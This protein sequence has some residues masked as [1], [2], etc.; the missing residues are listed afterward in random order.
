VSSDEHG[1]SVDR[2]ASAPATTLDACTM[3]I[4]TITATMMA[5]I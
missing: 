3:S 2:G 1:S 5:D 4:G